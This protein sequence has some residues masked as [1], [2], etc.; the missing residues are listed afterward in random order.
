MPPRA[1]DPA[2]DETVATAAPAAARHSA[3]SS[4]TAP[5]PVV[6][7]QEVFAT[8]LAYLTPLVT[9]AMLHE[10]GM[11]L[12]DG[13]EQLAWARL[14]TLICATAWGAEESGV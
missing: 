10:T 12:S 13:H 8:A 2:D 5:P 3:R 4:T 7:L 11:L 14:Y 1:H 9:E 6:T